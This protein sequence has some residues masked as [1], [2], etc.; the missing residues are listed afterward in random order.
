MQIKP[1]FRPLLASSLLLA[2]TLSTA[3]LIQTTQIS[4]ST[5]L[6]PL[7]VGSQTFTIDQLHD[8]ITADSPFNGFASNGI[9]SGSITLA[10]DQVYDL[11]SFVLWNDINVLNEGV[12]SFELRFLDASNMQIGSSGLLSAVSQLAPQT[13]SFSTV[14][15]VKSV[16]LDVSTASLQIEIRELAFNGNVSAVPEPASA[17]L[18]LAGLAAVAA[19][20][21]RR[22]SRG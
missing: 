16:V 2:S 3:A 8:G 10:L 7:T 5:L 22:A 4:A 6:M 18:V 19:S 21:R 1:L 13:Y 11:Q 17:V 20:A 15:G 12:R 9:K 14:A